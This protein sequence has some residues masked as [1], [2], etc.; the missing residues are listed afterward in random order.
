MNYTRAPESLD[1]FFEIEWLTSSRTLVF[2]DL[3]TLLMAKYSI[4]F[5][6][7]PL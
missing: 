1:K 5:F 6:F 4:V 3:S 2:C 7:L